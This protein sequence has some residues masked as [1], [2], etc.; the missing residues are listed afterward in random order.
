MLQFDTGKYHKE[1]ENLLGWKIIE[2][3]NEQISV[4]VVSLKKISKKDI[5]SDKIF[6]FTEEMRSTGMIFYGP[7]K[8]KINKILN[9]GLSE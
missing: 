2:S 8:R 1:K 5:L 7:Y 3:P 9:N 6:T 4:D